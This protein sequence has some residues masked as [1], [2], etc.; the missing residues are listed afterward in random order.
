MKI[1]NQD[2]GMN[3]KKKI[4]TGLIGAIFAPAIVA[5]IAYGMYG[6]EPEK[7]ADLSDKIQDVQEWPLPN[8]KPELYIFFV[9][10]RPFTTKRFMTDISGDMSIWSRRIE[11][12]WPGKYSSILWFVHARTTDRSGNEG[13][14]LA[15]K[16]GYKM[17]DIKAINWSEVTPESF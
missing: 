1:I 9:A 15:F 5:A 14:A 12:H 17:S 7:V 2:T 6:G 13:E 16:L 11:K 8:E 4:L 3:I 10:D